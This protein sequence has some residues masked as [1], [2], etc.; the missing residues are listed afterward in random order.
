V[1]FPRKHAIPFN[2]TNSK[3]NYA[4]WAHPVVKIFS[5]R[6]TEELFEHIV[7]PPI[8]ICECYFLTRIC[9]CYQ[10]WFLRLKNGSGY[11]SP[12]RFYLITM[13]FIKKK[14]P[15]PLETVP[16]NNAANTLD[17]RCL[18]WTDAGKVLRALQVTV[19]SRLAAWV[20]SQTN[21][22]IPEIVFD[23]QVYSL[24]AHSSLSLTQ[25]ACSI[26]VHSVSH[27]AARSSIHGFEAIS[28]Y[29]L[30]QLWQ[31]KFY[32][33]YF[34]LINF[35]QDGQKFKF[36]WILQKLLYPWLSSELPSHLRL[37]FALLWPWH[38][39]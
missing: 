12:F 6:R 17:C 24:Q 29:F 16:R 18:E 28:Q 36:S 10:W 32:Y 33:N 21:E 35:Q 22:S 7:W 19:S 9:V 37:E 2:V 25:L 13:A 39:E 5:Q 11:F 20:F 8:P 14:S 4:H 23:A 26:N 30:Y 31:D 1:S 3:L 34:H 27:L 38:S 15:R